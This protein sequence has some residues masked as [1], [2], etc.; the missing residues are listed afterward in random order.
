MFSKFVCLYQV[1]Q[2]AYNL[3]SHSLG[4]CSGQGLQ[5]CRVFLAD[6]NCS[7]GH[8]VSIN[9][10][11]LWHGFVQFHS[12]NCKQAEMVYLVTSILLLCVFC[13]CILDCIL[14]NLRDFYLLSIFDTTEGGVFFLSNFFLSSS[15]H[16]EQPSGQMARRL[17]CRGLLFEIIDFIVCPVHNLCIVS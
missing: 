11:P 4:S 9:S 2:Q 6:F 14:C 10:W 17:L 16:A 1:D 3:L 12:L 7:V 13:N 5:C 8:R 15:V